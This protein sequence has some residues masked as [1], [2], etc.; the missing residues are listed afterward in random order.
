MDKEVD[1][2]RLIGWLPYFLLPKTADYPIHE[3]FFIIE[4]IN[5]QNPTPTESQ[6]D[7]SW[8]TA[9]STYKP[10]FAVHILDWHHIT[11]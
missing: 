2:H 10:I 9:D 11:K 8:D 6:A 4:A 3:V 1:V 5:E 7:W